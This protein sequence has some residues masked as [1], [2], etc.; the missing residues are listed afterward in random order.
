MIFNLVCLGLFFHTGSDLLLDRSQ[1]LKQAR[2]DGAIVTTIKECAE[3]MNEAYKIFIDELAASDKWLYCMLEEEA[4]SLF[5]TRSQGTVANR[6]KFFPASHLYQR[7]L[8]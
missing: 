7:R 8:V 4:A 2:T 1:Q 3:D 5:L 6:S